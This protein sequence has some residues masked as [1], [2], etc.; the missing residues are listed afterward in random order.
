MAEAGLPSYAFD[1]WLGLL[2]PAG[3]PAAEVDRINAAVIKALAD[4]VVQER[5]ARVGVES[6]TMAPAAFQKLLKDDWAYSAKV[7]KAA[8]VRIE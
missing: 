6:G 8:D 7:V 4:P 2:A 5:L 3:T 1:S